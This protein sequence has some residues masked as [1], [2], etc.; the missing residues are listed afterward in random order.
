[1][2]I[3]GIRLEDVS[4]IEFADPGIE[5]EICHA[6]HYEVVA[7][8][9]IG[10]GVPSGIQDYRLI[11]KAGAVVGAFDVSDLPSRNESE[12]NNLPSTA[13]KVKLPVIVNGVIE[14]ND[15]DYFAFQAEPG[16]KLVFQIVS[17]RLGG[18]LDSVLTIFDSRGN[19]IAFNDDNGLRRDSKLIFEPKTKGEY[20]IQVNNAFPFGNPS[21][22]YRLS[23]GKLPSITEVFP[24]AAV[25]GQRTEFVIGGANL[26]QVQEVTLG[27]L[28]YRGS[29]LEKS[30]T[31]L[32]VQI[33]VPG[34]A[35]E[36]SGNIKIST[37]AL[38]LSSDQSISISQ[39]PQLA[40]ASA[41]SR[42]KP[43]SI[44]VPAGVSGVIEKDRAADYYEFEARAG[45]RLA[46]EVKALS[47]GSE[48]DPALFLY[49]SSGKLLVYQDEAVPWY[50]TDPPN[51]DP[52]LVHRFENA[53]R[54]K[55][56]VRDSAHNG[57]AGYFYHLSVRPAQPDFQLLMH[58]PAA[59][60]FRGRKSTITVR[61]RRFGGWDTPIEVWAETA[62]DAFKRVSGVAEPKNST[63]TD[64]NAKL[65]Q[66]NGT[67]VDLNIEVPAAARNGDVPILIR[68][69]G[70][71]AN[72]RK[73][74]HTVSA[75]YY[76]GFNGTGMGTIQHRD[77]YTTIADLPAVVM[78]APRNFAVAAGKS[79]KLR[80]NVTRFDEAATS[81]P[82]QIE[83]LPAG[84]S[85]ENAELPP[86]AG[87]IEIKLTA[88]S[89]ATPGTYRIR[90]KVQGVQSPWIEF[91]INAAPAKKP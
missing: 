91:K 44:P 53:G 16:E 11:G 22:Y 3:R 27:E 71:D 20:T 36:G 4:A 24:L 8:V 65:W 66:L 41:R 28:N 56:A 34:P 63:I 7:I 70:T 85:A 29:I 18:N 13:E 68:G 26:D 45:E 76:S 81:V 86:G 84:I 19:E 69:R 33:D 74:A 72:G 39:I 79:E 57:G 21:M 52:Y 87:L 9:K 67:D 58:K 82:V 30:P 59:T 62:G 46:I 60:L 51:H 64:C 1:M 6:E 49:D 75:L 61:V 32:T 15:V 55:L 73:V 89:A 80:I 12:P 43:Q 25:A 38:H 48:M 23:M 77:V 88:G 31:R 78:D 90:L 17:S 5:A 47:I 2:T 50:F 42:A 37:G 10:K 54:Y 83:D 40:S 35:P 14:N